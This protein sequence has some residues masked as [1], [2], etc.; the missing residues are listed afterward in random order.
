MQNKTAKS[1]Q[2][3]RH[4]QTNLF[5]C[6]SAETLVYQSFMLTQAHTT[7]HLSYYVAVKALIWYDREITF[8]Q[9]SAINHGIQ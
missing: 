8:A 6:E 2:L 7:S 4:L 5:S 3:W 9:H 1:V